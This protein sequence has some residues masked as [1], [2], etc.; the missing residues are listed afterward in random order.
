MATAAHSVCPLDCPDRCSLSVQVEG[1]RLVSID[2]SHVNPVTD[3][4]ICAKVRDYGRRVNG[5]E[6]LL[7]PLRRVGAKGE[8]RF[9]RVSWDEA[10]DQVASAFIDKAARHGSETVWPY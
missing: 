3:G 10:L 9:E 4:F 2:G 1:G 6:R 7:H 8:G 5:P